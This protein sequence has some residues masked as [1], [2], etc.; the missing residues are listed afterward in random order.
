MFLGRYYH[1]LE[2]KGRL[3]IPASFRQ[4]LGK[5][6]IL[7]RGLDSCLYLFS[8]TTW[9]KL[10]ADL[11]TSPLAPEDTRTLTRLLAHDAQILEFDAQGRSLLNRELRQFAH[12][13]KQVVVAGSA[14]WVEIWDQ[15]RYHQYLNNA[16]TNID[17]IAARI[18]EVSHE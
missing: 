18:R 12:L 8:S 2:D 15:A 6:P 11:N 9:S 10:I 13:T 14:T 5:H 17:Q 1:S 4:L 3:A 16:Q 7:T